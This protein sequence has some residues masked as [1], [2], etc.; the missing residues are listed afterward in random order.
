LYFAQAVAVE[1]GTT[2]LAP[3][4]SIILVPSM[5]STVAYCGKDMSGP[6]N[7]TASGSKSITGTLIYEAA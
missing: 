3:P 1:D 6:G 2:P 5:S 4:G 7:F